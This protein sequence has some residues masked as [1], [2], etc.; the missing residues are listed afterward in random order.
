MVSEGGLEPPRPIRAL[1]LKLALS[2]NSATPTW[3]PDRTSAK[4]NRIG[5]LRGQPPCDSLPAGS[6]GGR[7]QPLVCADARG[8]SH[9]A[10]GRIAAGTAD[11]RRPSTPP[12]PHGPKQIERNRSGLAG[13]RRRG[14]RS[15]R[16]PQ[17]WQPDAGQPQRRRCRPTGPIRAR[18]DLSRRVRSR[19]VDARRDHHRDDPS[20]ESRLRTP[21]HQR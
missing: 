18:A 12:L 13:G 10:S 14:S 2:A 3:P 9:A 20:H 1:A 7:R 8:C 15:H 6:T 5:A 16:R 11:R 4:K 21:V 19:P 17:R